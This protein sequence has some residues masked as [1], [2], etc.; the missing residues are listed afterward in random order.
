MSEVC[1]GKE[2]QTDQAGPEPETPVLTRRQLGLLFGGGAALVVGGAGF[3]IVARTE[4]QARTSAGTAFGSLTLLRAG[5]LA[6]LQAD[7]TPSP[8]VGQPALSLLPAPGTVAEAAVT[9]PGPSPAVVLAGHGQG[10]SG[11]GWPQPV[12]LTWGD[13]VL[14]ELQVRNT[15]D[16]P[17]T[18]SPGQLRLRA[19]RETITPQ[20]AGRGPGA[21]APGSAEQLWISYLVPASAADFAVEFTDPFRD[22]TSV[23]RLP[24]LVIVTARQA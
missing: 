16:G 19:G 6:R 1:A 14:L 7:G 13:V 9:A 18:F 4:Q 23:L 10:H 24:P 22:N 21:L 3:G 8:L 20:R 17:I 15:G 11:S 2:R 5:R 12:N